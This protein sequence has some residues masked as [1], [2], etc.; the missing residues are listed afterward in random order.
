M[1]NITRELLFESARKMLIAEFEKA[2]LEIPHYGERGT[3]TEQIVIKW[4]TNH[5]PQ[6]FA[7]SG[8]FIILKCCSKNVFEP[9]RAA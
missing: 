9:L 2:K 6:R 7:A 1:E 5:L 8:G 4:L 3:E